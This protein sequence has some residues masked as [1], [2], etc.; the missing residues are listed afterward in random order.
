MAVVRKIQLHPLFMILC[1][2]AYFFGLF[3]ELFCL[4][5]IVFIHEMGHYIAA[6]Y[7]KWNVSKIVI[8][9]FGGVMETEDYYNRPSKEELIVT[10][11]GP[12]QH[13]WLYGAI[14]I[15]SY[16]GVQDSFLFLLLAMN[17]A[18]LLFNLLPILPLDGGR[19][20]FI[21]LN[22]LLSFHKSI[23]TMTLISIIL[24]GFLNGI[25]L[26]IGWYNIQIAWI[27]IFLLLDNWFT[28]REKH[29]FLLKHLLSRYFVQNVDRSDIHLLQVPSG[30]PVTELVKL[31]KKGCYHYI[32]IG[33]D[34]VLS[35][36][37]CLKILFTD[38]ERTI[39]NDKLK[40]EVI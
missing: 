1:V 36:D 7:F 33:Q 38:R 23:A 20:I 24:I 39:S 8:W 25:L 15:L 28:W 32:H 3:A 29:I 35:E 9:P 18:I 26:F 13:V 5:L 27:S 40:A 21:G 16:V 2:V 31:F 30:T 10:I 34:V 17:T 4:T 22:Q 6:R 12:L 19:V 11:A 37:E 14:F